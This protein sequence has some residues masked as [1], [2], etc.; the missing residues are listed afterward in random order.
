V[1]DLDLIALAQ[2]ECPIP[3]LEPGAE[4]AGRYTVVRKL[5]DGVLGSIWLVRDGTDDQERLLELLREDYVVELEVDKVLGRARRMREALPSGVL[6]PVDAGE[7]EEHPFLVTEAPGRRSLREVLDVSAGGLPARQVR[8]LF[9]PILNLARQLHSKVRHSGLNANNIYIGDEGE[10]WIGQLVTYGLAEG[11]VFGG[12]GLSRAG[13]PYLAPELE[14]YTNR[15]GAGADVYSFGVLLYEALCGELPVGRY[16]L[17]SALRDDVPAELDEV[18][19]LALAGD[20][21]ERFQSA[22]DLAMAI[23]QAFTAGGRKE[24]KA[25]MARPLM[26]ALLGLLALVVAGAFL[27][28]PPTEEDLLAA[29]LERRTALRAEVAATAADGGQKGTAPSA[30][31]VWIPG[32]PYIAG[33]FETQEPL[34][35]TSER[36]EKVVD[37]PGFWIDVAPVQVPDGDGGDYKIVNGMTHDEAVRICE[38]FGKRLCSEDEWEK[39]CKGPNSSLYAYGDDFD[40]ERCPS[41]GF[42]TRYRVADFPNCVGGYGVLGMSG[43]IGEWTDT[44]RG[45]MFIIKP[46]MVG[47]APTYSRCAGQAGLEDDRVEG[48]VGMRCCGP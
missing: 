21:R 24:D 39:A 20:S 48:N 3:E 4:L 19:E 45:E 5:S 10:V 40:P 27:L 18:V 42:N 7:H 47:S 1:S 41:P 28:Q 17:P 6:L 30:G 9:L 35:G 15:V 34:A 36:A 29:E 23:E 33:R 26:L 13:D 31:M 46:A 43:G 25:K 2:E 8:D 14:Q 12:E 44:Q 37:V 16:E 32:G 11:D 38:K 22:D